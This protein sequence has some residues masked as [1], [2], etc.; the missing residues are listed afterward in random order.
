MIYVTDMIK[1]ALLAK[2]SGG[3]LNF[4]RIGR[5][6]PGQESVR[7][8]LLPFQVLDWARDFLSMLILNNQAAMRSA[9]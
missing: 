3:Q 8:D 7:R 2:G 5:L 4:R 6:P 9:S 1:P